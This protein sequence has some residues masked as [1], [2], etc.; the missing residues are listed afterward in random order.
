LKIRDLCQG[1]A[2]VLKGYA[3]AVL[4]L[5]FA[6]EPNYSKLEHLLKMELLASNHSPSDLRMDWSLWKPKTRL[7]NLR[8]DGA[9]SCADLSV[10]DELCSAGEGSYLIADCNAAV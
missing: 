8:S 2:K 10:G 3:K 9:S 7:D 1:E 4:K 5:K 6:E